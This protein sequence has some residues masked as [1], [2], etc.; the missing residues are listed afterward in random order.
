[1][2]AQDR[3]PRLAYHPGMA[4]S[5]NS[6]MTRPGLIAATAIVLILL[7]YALLAPP[8]SRPPSPASWQT[9]ST[10]WD[11]PLPERAAAAGIAA[12]GLRYL[13]Q[14]ED[15]RI[16][17]RT[18]VIEKHP[19]VSELRI[20][21]ITLRIEPE[22]FSVP[23]AAMEGVLSAARPTLLRTT[24]SFVIKD[25]I[26]CLKDG[27]CAYRIELTVREPDGRLTVE[28]SARLAIPQRPVVID[29]KK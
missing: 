18:L 22:R 15:L 20:V 8:P 10:G 13:Q 11:L 3:C 12:N 17:L 5:R 29:Q 24:V 26:A 25:G 19:A 7:F 6:R 1:M 9:H 16:D 4:V 23:E 28:R 21:A 14:G 2:L 27:H